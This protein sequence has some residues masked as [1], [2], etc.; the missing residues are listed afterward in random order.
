MTT[1]LRVQVLGLLDGDLR[2]IVWVQQDNSAIRCGLAHPGID[3]HVTLREGEGTHHRGKGAVEIA[4]AMTYMPQSA[5]LDPKGP[6]LIGGWVFSDLKSDFEKLQTYTADGSES[7]VVLDLAS[8]PESFGV[9]VLIANAR[10]IYVP[11]LI[12]QINARLLHVDTSA[13]P[14]VVIRVTSP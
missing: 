12:S 3:L 4:A 1:K 6:Q 9:E 2:T 8:L 10:N 11:G 13:T 14:A 5:S 7:Q